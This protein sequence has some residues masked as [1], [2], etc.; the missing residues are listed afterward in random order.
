MIKTAKELVA[1]CIDAAN[2]YKTLYVMGCFGAPMNEKN[3]T[4]WING[5]AYNRKEERKAKIMDASAD[6]FGFDCV[7]FI[8]GLLWGWCG[9]PNQVYGGAAYKSNGVPDIGADQMLNACYEVSDDF[10]TIV[11]GELVW[12]PGHA[13]IYIGDGKAVEATPDEADGVQIQ[14]VLPMGTIEGM[15][16]TGW[17]KHGKLPWISYE[18]A[19]EPVADSKQYRV[20]VEGLSKTHAEN[21]AQSYADTGCTVRIEEME[22]EPIPGDKP[23]EPV[24]EVK[25]AEPIPA[26]QPEPEAPWVPEE[27]DI[28][29]F[30]GD[31]QYSQAN[32]TTAKAA[33]KGQARINKIVPGT[34]HPYSLIRTGKTG[35]Y[36]W[37]DAGTFTKA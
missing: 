21:L 19:Q 36:G 31:V 23:T 29:N 2:N 20:I 6:T 33:N 27:G 5:Y 13:G 18:A 16:C 15:P 24:P 7:C 8:K 28:V 14:A 35:P 22:A 10:S 30:H 3:K 11:P 32:G 17:T 9:D 12:Q 1:A 34:K 26:P 4:R 37:V 25:P